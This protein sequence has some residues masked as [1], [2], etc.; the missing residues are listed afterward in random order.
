MAYSAEISRQKPTCL[1]FVIDRSTSMGMKMESGHSKAAFLADVLNKTIYTL[2]TNCTKADGVRDYFHI[3]VIAYS[4]ENAYSG[5]EN[6]LSA[7][8]IYPISVLA[9]NP[10]RVE[11]RV[12][13]I[14][15][16]REQ[17][18]NRVKFPV[19]FEP[20]S[21]GKTSMCAGFTKA[22]TV[23]VEWC[24]KYFTSYPPTVLHVTDGH[25]TDGDPESLAQHL[26]MIGTEDGGALLFNLHVDIGREKAT[27]FPSKESDLKDKYAKR[28]FRMSSLL[29]PHL[30]ATAR[31]RGYILEGA[32]RGFIY[33]ADPGAIVDFFEIG[34]RPQVMSER[35]GNL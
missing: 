2:I 18:E 25:P 16:E 8:C 17:I 1:I 30:I 27:T 7:N 24:N 3:G 35:A 29:P 21:G 34:T 23:L 4:G 9:N 33:N 32:A 13:K 15:T 6:Q 5:F 10:L 20:K 12:Q 28:L 22:S 26:Q 19:W 14:Q 31:S 11:E